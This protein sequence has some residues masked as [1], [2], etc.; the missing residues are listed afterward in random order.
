MDKLDYQLGEMNIALNPFENEYA[1]KWSCMYVIFV[2]LKCMGEK[3]NNFSYA[4]HNINA[5]II[6]VK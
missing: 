4:K 1:Y 5:Y 2:L 3:S 6:S